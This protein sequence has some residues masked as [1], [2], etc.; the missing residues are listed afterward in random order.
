MNRK[1]LLAVAGVS[2][3]VLAVMT[4]VAVTG[5][6]E[7]RT[8]SAELLPVQ[9]QGQP[10]MKSS[11]SDSSPVLYRLSQEDETMVR[12]IV[13][14]D[15]RIK[16]LIRGRDY[17]FSVAGHPIEGKDW[18]IRAGAVLKDNVGFEELNRW[19]EEGQR[20]R[21]VIAEIVAVLSVGYNDC[22]LISVD[23]EKA[24]IRQITHQP[25]PGLAIPEL[26]KQEK[27]RAV[28]IALDDPRVQ[29][30]LKGK[31]YVVAPEGTIV[32]WHTTKDRKKIGA[33]LEIWFDKSYDIEYDWPWPEYDEKKYPSFPYYQE[34][35]LHESRVVKALAVL[36]DLE[37]GKVA[38]I[39]NRPVGEGTED[40][41][42]SKPAR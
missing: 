32:V 14:S 7:D 4:S 26:T 41:F 35:T 39:M 42:K 30:L 11:T 28:M 13:L 5:L 20:D 31:S 16:E 33:G 21:R 9:T 15:S 36:I 19:L 34:K 17:A 25:R 23:M 37:K 3:L 10:I 40:L 29:E 22:Y 24:N 38:G 18:D 8:A 27:E 2:L 1:L 6:N 12:E